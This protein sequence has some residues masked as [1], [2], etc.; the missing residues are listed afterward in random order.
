VQPTPV[1]SGLCGTALQ[2]LGPPP[3]LVTQ[4]FLLLVRWRILAQPNARSLARSPTLLNHLALNQKQT[5]QFNKMKFGKTLAVT[6]AVLA[7][8]QMGKSSMGKRLEHIDE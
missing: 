1:P 4:Y 6:L 2:G 7:V 8:S 5:N 3:V